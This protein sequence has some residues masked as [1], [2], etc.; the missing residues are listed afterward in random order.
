MAY[1]SDTIA[2]VLNRLNIQYFLPAIQREFVW[3]T[4]Q[5]I[6]FFDSLMRGYPI[7]SFLFW[8]LKP[9]NYDKWQV[10]R[11][12]SDYRQWTTHNELASTN[13]I[14][15]LTLVL[16]GQQRLTS[17]LIGLKGTYTIKKKYKRSDN[18]DAWTRQVLYLDLLKEAKIE[19]EDDTD[20]GVRY[21]FRFMEKGKTPKQ[22]TISCWFE[23]GKI[24]DFDSEDR[25]D[26]F[27]DDLIE[28][29]PDDLTK[30]QLSIVRRNLD[31][32]YRSMWSEEFISYYVEHD[33]DYDRVLDIFVRANQGGTPL[34]KSDLL[35]SMVTAKWGDINAREEIYGFV[36]YLN[37]GLTHKNNF[38]KDFVMKTCLVLSDLPVQYMVRNFSNQNLATIYHNWH[39]IKGAIEKGVKLVNSFGIDADR[40]TSANAL[41]PVLYYLHRHPNLMLLGTSL[42][43]VENA[44]RIRRWLTMALL[45]NVFSGASDN[46]LRDTRQVLREQ[47]AS[48]NNFPVTELN[49]QIAKSGRTATFDDYAV[50]NFL[51]I[52]Y[53]KP[54]AFLALS[55]LYDV[56]TWGTT[57]FQQDHIFPQSLF[58]KGHM[59]DLGLD[60]ER[61]DRYGALVNRIG[62]LQLITAQENSSKSDQDFAQWLT[63]RTPTFQQRHLIPGDPALLAFDRF[64]EFIMAREELIKQRLRH[65]FLPVKI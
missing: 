48:E 14:Q 26:D 38:N 2:A 65:L 61:Q 64:E 5:I 42:F 54:T 29:L 22:D 39:G 25:F 32:L 36:D 43:D 8:Q 10:Y 44:S 37:N 18:P 60:T 12:I 34:S 28:D 30:R 21:G 59:A 11:F 40:L 55:L 19:D 3:D 15:Q 35:L 24:L 1:Q 23:V 13:G 7:G 6:Q 4:D 58:T 47:P 16:D 51:S 53:G 49:A 31:R 45:N 52:S 9:E 57:T 46:M 20:I 27:K 41:I 63:T 33:Q 62:N 56:E 50:D 17:L